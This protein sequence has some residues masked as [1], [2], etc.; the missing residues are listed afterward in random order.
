[1]FERYEKQINYEK[2]G[3]QGQALL[4]KS[5]VLIV[6][7]GALGTVVANN[8]VRMGIGHI[9]IVDRDFV[10]I[11]NLHRQIL[12]DEED[13][14]ENR[15]KAKSAEAKLKKINSDIK[16]EGLVKEVNSR[17]LEGLIEG[18]DLIIDCT[19]NFKTRY[20]INDVAFK[21]NLPWVYGGALGSSGMMK[22][23]IPKEKKG[24]F[25]CAFPKPPESGSLP[26]CDTVGVVNTLTA[27]V[28]SLESNEALKYFLGK[29]DE[30]E[31]N[32]VFID[33]WDNTFEK[34]PQQKNEACPCCVEGKFVYLEDKRAES[35]YICGQNSIQIDLGDTTMNLKEIQHRLEKNNILTRLNLSLLSFEVEGVEVKLFKDGRAIMKNVKNE[36]VAKSIYAKYIGY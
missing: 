6:G 10:E 15:P 18:M 17:T 8:L 31:K 26:T 30:V 25:Q 1:M 4:E 35:I 11:T 13:V 16:I 7:C 21:Y 19:D 33:L 23:F 12:F 29:I 27:I 3:H 14:K 9:R 20:L 28:G 22:F 32:L 34:I 36:E 24:C 2:I 5:K